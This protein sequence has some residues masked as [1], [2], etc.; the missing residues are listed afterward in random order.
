M[1]AS[2]D[3]ELVAR[4]KKQEGDFTICSFVPFEF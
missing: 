4:E 3:G 2:G 1:F